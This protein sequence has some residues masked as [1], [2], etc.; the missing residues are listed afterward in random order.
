[1]NSCLQNWFAF[2]KSLKKPL[3]FEHGSIGFIGTNNTNPPPMDENNNAYCKVRIDQKLICITFITRLVVKRYSQFCGT[4]AKEWW[5]VLAKCFRVFL[6]FQFVLFTRGYS[7]TPTVLIAANHST[8]VSGNSAPVH[9]GISTWIEVKI[10]LVWH[11]TVFQVSC[12]CSEAFRRSLKKIPISAVKRCLDNQRNWM[13]KEW[14]I[15][16]KF[17]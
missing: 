17:M 14:L 8:K 6:V 5:N 13:L 1:M 7:S 3:S 11:Y 15:K 10:A 9:N 2:S 12:K 4:L 16:T